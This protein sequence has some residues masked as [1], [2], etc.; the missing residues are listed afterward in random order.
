MPDLPG[1][2]LVYVHCLRVI[3]S[4]A[5]SQKMSW[6]TM[7]ILCIINYRIIMFINFYEFRVQS[8]TGKTDYH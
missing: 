2:V 3:I 1:T 4:S 7:V 5:H 6:P 8:R